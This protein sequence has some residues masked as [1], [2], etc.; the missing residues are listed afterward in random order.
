MTPERAREMMKG[1]NRLTKGEKTALKRSLGRTPSAAPG[2]MVAFYRAFPGVREGKELPFFLCACGACAMA[3]LEGPE[4]G[5]VAAMKA[6]ATKEYEEGIRR[7]LLAL[8]DTPVEFET[9]FA[10]KVGRLL[11]YMKAKGIKV[12]FTKLL[13]DLCAWDRADGRVQRKWA[14]EYFGEIK[15]E[16]DKEDDEDADRDAHAQELSANESEP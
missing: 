15:G 8:L 1:I 12:D 16:N 14:R 13:C 4:R 7:K 5:V 2:A 11:R 3:R 9:L 10:A 6:L